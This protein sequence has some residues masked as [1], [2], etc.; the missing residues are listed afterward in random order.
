MRRCSSSKSFSGTFL[1]ISFDPPDKLSDKLAQSCAQQG[2][3]FGHSGEPQ[4]RK[5]LLGSAK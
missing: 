2:P 1:P 5:E 3:T 4:V